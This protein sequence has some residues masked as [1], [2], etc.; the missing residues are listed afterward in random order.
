MNRDHFTGKN[1][2]IYAEGLITL[3]EALESISKFKGGR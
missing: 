3:A 1:T 2:I